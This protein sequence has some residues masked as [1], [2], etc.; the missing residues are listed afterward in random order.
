MQIQVNSITR[1]ELES[2]RFWKSLAPDFAMTDRPFQQVDGEYRLSSQEAERVVRQ[3]QSE[4]YFQ[5]EPVIPESDLRPIAALVGKLHANG[6]LPVFAAVY[7][8]LWHLLFRLRNT[9][10]PILDPEYILPPDFWL[11]HISPGSNNRGWAPH[12]DAKFQAVSYLR[13]DGR[14]RMCTVWIPFTDATT[15]NSCIY[16]LPRPYDPVF[17]GYL[18]GE[19]SAAM[20]ALGQQT[21]ISNFRAL[22]AR[23]GSLLGWVPYLL[24]WGSRSTEWATHPRIS[25]GIYYISADQPLLARTFDASGRK[26]IDFKSGE[27]CALT[28]ANRLT[29]I[30]NI[31]DTYRANGQMVHEPN[32]TEAAAA[33]CDKWRLQTPQRL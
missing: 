29:I 26:H 25:I 23:A 22:P 16:V 20:Q 1:A 27:A 24:H 13:P 33:F 15:H 32:F 14:P 28:L 21:D 12:R 19:S 9:L 10:A 8:E 11:W 7:D 2:E 31:L 18:R 30:A 4:G 17:Q 6:I 5:T 3:I